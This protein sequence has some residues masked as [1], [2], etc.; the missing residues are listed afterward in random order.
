MET[1]ST[2]ILEAISEGDL[3]RTSLY[4]RGSTVHQYAELSVS[5]KKIDSLCESIIA[6]LNKANEL[7]SLAAG[8]EAELKKIGQ[9]LYDQL[10]SDSVKEKLTNIFFFSYCF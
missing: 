3:I 1:S 2:L 5:S 8:L 4:D 9:L 10:I 6:L 7:G